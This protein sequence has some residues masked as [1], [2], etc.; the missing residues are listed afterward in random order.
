MFCDTTIEKAKHKI[1]HSHIMLL[2]IFRF[3]FFFLGF[4]PRF[5]RETKNAGIYSMTTHG[6]FIIFLGYGKAL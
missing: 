1:W 4:T 6:F 3:G 2:K 5:M